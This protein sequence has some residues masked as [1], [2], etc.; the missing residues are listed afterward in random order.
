MNQEQSSTNFSLINEKQLQGYDGR[1]AALYQSSREPLLCGF[2]P[3]DGGTK[4]EVRGEPPCVYSSGY[5]SAYAHRDYPYA[6]AYSEVAK[7]ARGARLEEFIP[8]EVAP[9]AIP[10]KKH[11]A[12]IVFCPPEKVNFAGDPFYEAAVASGAK[13]EVNGG[14]WVATPNGYLY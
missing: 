13:V 10:L 1:K 7:I 11:L 9:H 3:S 5:P 12:K 4:A 8:K 6:N 14:V 2:S